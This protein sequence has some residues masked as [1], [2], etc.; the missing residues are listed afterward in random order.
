MFNYEHF[1]EYMTRN[2]SIQGLS[3][4]CAPARGSAPNTTQ[5]RQHTYFKQL[6][7]GTPQKLAVYERGWSEA[8]HTPYNSM[9]VCVCVCACVVVYFSCRSHC[10]F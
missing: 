2:S 6:L 10:F 5:L 3:V 7:Q 4:T 8:A 9:G 1:Y